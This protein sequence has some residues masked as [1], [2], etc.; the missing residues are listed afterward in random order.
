MKKNIF[1]IGRIEITKLKF[2]VCVF[3]FVVVFIALEQCNSAK[4]N[5]EVRFSE[6]AQSSCPPLELKSAEEEEQL[7][8][9]F[10]KGRQTLQDA[11]EKWFLDNSSDTHTYVDFLTDNSFPPLS[12]NIERLFE[13]EKKVDNYGYGECHGFPYELYQVG[14]DPTGCAYFLARQHCKTGSFN[15][16]EYF[17]NA[18]MD[19]HFHWNIRCY[20]FINP[21]GAVSFC[22][23]LKREW[24]LDYDES[25]YH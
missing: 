22:N 8:L 1:A 3:V 16:S 21:E 13:C 14:C 11:L 5:P 10:L 4:H 7:I 18:D 19:E 2:A 25:F 12:I 24:G 20:S 15:E 9:P 17:I 6:Q 23:Y